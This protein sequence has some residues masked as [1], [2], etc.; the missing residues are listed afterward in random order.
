MDTEDITVSERS[1]GQ[2]VVVSLQGRLDASSSPAAA[3][4]IAAV[5]GRRPHAVVLDLGGLTYTS[6]SGLRVMLTALKEVRKGGGDLSIAGPQP[7]VRDV[8]VTAGFDRIIPIHPDVGEAV[9]AAEK[10]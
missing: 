4:A 10:K 2:A 5:T 1:E 7:R 3:E 9:Q 8:L 6:S